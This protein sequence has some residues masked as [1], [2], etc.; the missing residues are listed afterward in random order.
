MKRKEDDD[1]VLLHLDV[2]R[3]Y[4]YAKVREEIYVQLPEDMIESGEKV[5][6]KLIQGHVWDARRS[7]CMV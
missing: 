3:A 7:I 1:W 2:R 5:C 4:F 6:G